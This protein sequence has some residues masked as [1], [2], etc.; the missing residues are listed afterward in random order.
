MKFRKKYVNMNDFDFIIIGGGA[1][2]TAFISSIY[3][4]ISKS[5]LYYNLKIG[6]IDKK[7]NLGCGNIYNQDYPWILMNTPSTDLSVLI[8]NPY[9][10]SEWVDQYIDKSSLYD[11]EAK[12]LPRSIF[13]QYLKQKYYFFKDELEKKG[14]LIENINDLSIDV[15]YEENKQDIKIILKSGNYVKAKYIIF[16]TGP[17]ISEDHYNL[18]KYK[19]YIHNPFPA[20]INLSQ[21]PKNKDVAIIGS[22]LTAIDIAITLKHLDHK[23][24]IIMAS[25]NGKL[26]EVKGSYLK[27]YPPKNALYINYENISKKKNKPLDLFDLIRLI[28]K[29]LKLHGLH[30]R[31]YFFEKEQKPECV[32]DFRN[33][34]KEAREKETSFNIILGIIPE[35]AK[36]WRL[37]S[38]DKI[39]IFMKNFYRNIHQKHGAIPIINA[40]KILTMLENKKLI[41]KGNLNKIIYKNNNYTL[42]F[43]KNCIIK[44]EYIINATG[45]KRVVCDTLSK[46][47][48]N[49]SCTNRLIKEISIGGIIIDTKTGMLL[50]KDGTFERKLR[51]I[52]HNAEGSHPFINNFAW[53]LESTYEI[54][55]SLLLEVTNDK[56]SQ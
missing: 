22:N 26:P 56:K 1:Q 54:A 45:P 18:K 9:D 52:G 37:L 42:Y 28:R 11:K 38:N 55:E 4:I 32:D 33:R 7:E 46:L 40:E 27:S 2:A 34:V 20:N 10:F 25:R 41:L 21:I 53:I 8:N 24:K 29:E 47:P 30:W 51:A 50:K 31:E 19:N 43:D 17:N 44:T 14:V 36:T 49:N 35:I 15:I 48:F 6:V 16:A 13:G 12:F 23:G 39:E 3:Y 5:N